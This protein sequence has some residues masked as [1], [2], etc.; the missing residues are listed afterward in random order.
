[1]S[2]SPSTNATFKEVWENLLAFRNDA[3]LWWQ[4]GE[5]AYD[6]FLIRNRRRT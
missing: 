3:Y 4:V 2:N 5:Y 1:M 6:D